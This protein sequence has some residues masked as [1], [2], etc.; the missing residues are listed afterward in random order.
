MAGTTGKTDWLSHEPG[1]LQE[2]LVW[3]GGRQGRSELAFED[4]PSPSSWIE[5]FFCASTF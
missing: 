3:E 2:E 4:V 1:S 5:L